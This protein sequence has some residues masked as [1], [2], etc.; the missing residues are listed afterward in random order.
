MEVGVANQDSNVSRLFLRRTDNEAGDVV[1]AEIRNA[2]LDN[3]EV[4]LGDG[5]QSNAENGDVDF[6]ASE[7]VILRVTASDANS[8]N[9]GGS[10]DVSIPFSVT[11]YLTLLSRVKRFLKIEDSVQ[12]AD[13]VLNDL[14]TGCS[15]AM[16]AWMGRKIVQQAITGEIYD[17][18]TVSFIRDIALQITPI[19]SISEVKERGTAIDSGLYKIVGE[20]RVRR[21]S[22]SLPYYWTVGEVEFAY[23]GG[24]LTIPEDLAGVAT[25][26]VANAYKQT[27]HGG[28]RLGRI[29]DSFSGHTDSQ[30]R[31]WD[32]LPTTKTV[33]NKYRRL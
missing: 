19:M 28:D 20:N 24:F 5:V 23:T 32:W 22:S 7:N 8:M 9:L 27:G 3:L 25:N 15:G 2:G 4:T 12:T 13:A 14:I 16:E 18:S 1:V 33:M 31:E 10:F 26:E 29:A 17:V 21:L 6:L 30:Y 11:S